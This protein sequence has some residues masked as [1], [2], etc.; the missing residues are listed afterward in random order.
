MMGAVVKTIF[1]FTSHLWNSKNTE[2]ILARLELRSNPMCSQAGLRVTDTIRNQRA[3]EIRTA[4]LL[5]LSYLPGTLA[6][7]N[8]SFQASYCFS[9]NSR[10]SLSVWGTQV[11]V[12]HRK[13]GL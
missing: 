6:P 2:I 11:E 3:C 10:L 13:E 1:L 7:G 9:V 5:Q 12:T 8:L 4:H